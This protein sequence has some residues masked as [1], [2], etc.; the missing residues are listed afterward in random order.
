MSRI[1]SGKLRLDNQMIDPATFIEEAIESLRPTATAKGIRLTVQLE[2]ERGLVAG[3]AG[4]LQQVIWNLLSNA[5]KF[6]PRDGAV[7]VRLERMQGHVAISVTDTGKGIAPEFLPFVFDR[8]RQADA[9]ITRTVGGLGL[10][11][12]IVKQLVEMHGGSVQCTSNGLD[13]G[14]RFTVHLPV[15]IE[16]ELPRNT[17]KQASNGVRKTTKFH[18]AD[19]SGIRIL[20]VDDSPDALDLVKRVLSE[21][22][23]E[24]LTASSAVEAMALIESFRPDVVVS[25][26]GMPDVNGYELLRKVR[27]LPSERGGAI[28]AIALTAFARSEDRTRALRAGFQMHVSKPVEPAELVATVASVVR[29]VVPVDISHSGKA[30]APK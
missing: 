28:P 29:R 11:L 4:R 20:V 7:D 17:R 6:T 21:C 13:T 18:R 26:I 9:S 25:D 12:S 16:Q 24:V 15:V 19:L 22:D 30:H 10:G 27:A 5:L 1:T 8:F 2:R 3:D 14:A 23:A